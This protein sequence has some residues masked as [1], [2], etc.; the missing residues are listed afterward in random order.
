MNTNTYNSSIEKY[1]KILIDILISEFKHNKINLKNITSYN[2]YLSGF[3]DEFISKK[4]V[5]ASG[6]KFD[7]R[8]RINN[9][10]VSTK[11]KLNE[12]VKNI[13]EDIDYIFEMAGK[14]K[15]ER[16]K[17]ERKYKSVFDNPSSEIKRIIFHTK[18]DEYS[19]INSLIIPRD[20][21]IHQNKRI[22]LKIINNLLN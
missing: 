11:A 18:S 8:M 5:L 20:S 22:M 21:H 16:F 2:C 19:N 10:R 4:I 12:T 1:D 3:I 7:V 13:Y 9:V 15:R 17:W 14:P 6:A